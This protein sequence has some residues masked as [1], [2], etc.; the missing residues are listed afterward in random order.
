MLYRKAYDKLLSWKQG[1]KKKALFIEGVRQCG[2]TTVVREFAKNEYPCYAELNFLTE[3][4]TKKIFEGGSGVKSIIEGITAYTKKELIPGK[5]L[6][7]LDE[8]EECPDARTAVKMLVEDGR[9]DYV[10]TGSLLGIKN[11]LVRSL[12]VGFEENYR[13]YPMDWEEF[14]TA[15][16]VQMSTIELTKKAYEERKTLNAFVHENMLKLFHLYIIVGG[17]PAAVQEYVD[18]NDIGAVI[19]A[20]N[21]ILDLYKQDIAKY[22][23]LK[24]RHKIR[25]IFDSIPNELNSKNR[26]FRLTSLSETARME[27]YEDSFNW[28]I[29]A[30]VAL[31][32]YNVSEPSGALKLNEKRNLL[33]LFLA[34]TGLLCAL[35]MDNIQFEILNGNL[36]INMGSILENMMAQIF[37][38]DGYSLHYFDSK[39]YGKLDFV[40]QSGSGVSFVEIKSGADYRKHTA[41]DNVRRIGNWK[42]NKAYVFSLSN[43][44]EED[45]ILYLPWYMAPFMRQS[46]IP[47][48]T[49]YHVDVTALNNGAGTQSDTAL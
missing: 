25:A 12:P 41:L 42:D 18:S 8:I 26:R 1:K 21:T 5:T 34:D 24:D 17:M 49:I 11:R 3:P 6:I 13:M 19:R 9:F 27:R 22:A 48:G 32:A 40:L 15:V 30:G 16:G 10:E 20:Q 45:G 38:A 23:E 29:D 36:E 44:F 2:K 43:V 33:K 28:L 39:K 14:L 7:L 31:P 4:E 35:S 47:E 37:T 46:V